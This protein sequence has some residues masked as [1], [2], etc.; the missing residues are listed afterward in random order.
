MDC[1]REVVDTIDKHDVRQIDGRGWAI[2]QPTS[3]KR[4]VPLDIS[5][6]PVGQESRDVQQ[7]PDYPR[8]VVHEKTT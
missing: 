8:Q 1:S 2:R 5:G 6:L 3:D 7:S 4:Q